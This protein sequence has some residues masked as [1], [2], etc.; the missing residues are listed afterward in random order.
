MEESA[1]IQSRKR[2]RS[3]V[4]LSSSSNPLIGILTRRKSRIYLHH[5]RSGI[6]RPDPDSRKPISFPPD[7]GSVQAFWG[8]NCNKASRVSS[9]K[10]LRSRRVFTPEVSSLLK[11][12]EEDLKD[13]ST[14]LKGSDR[15][16]AP[17]LI[18][19]SNVGGAEVDEREKN[20]I[21]KAKAVDEG[22]D[23]ENSLNSKDQSISGDG[24]I[25]VAKLALNRCGRKKVFRTPSSFSY[26]R[27]LPYLMDIVNDDSSV[28]KIEIV[29][30][31]TPCKL[32]KLDGA[33]SEV[34]S[35]AENSYTAKLEV[36]VPHVD[37]IKPS[38]NGDVKK[39]HIELP[40]NQQDLSGAEHGLSR[41]TEMT[42]PIEV[43]PKVHESGANRIDTSVGEECG[44]TTPP[45]RDVF[46]NTEIGPGGESMKANSVL[47]ENQIVKGLSVNGENG[48]IDVLR[49]S[50]NSK[51]GTE[52]INRLVPNPCSRLRL[53]KNPRSLS[54][55]RL[56]PF[57]MDMSKNNSCNSRITE[58]STAQAYLK[59][60]LHPLSTATT[61]KDYVNKTIVE[62]SSGVQHTQVQMQNLFSS[63]VPLPPSDGSSPDTNNSPVSS[64]QQSSSSNYS[65]NAEPSVFS[66]ETC[67]DPMLINLQTGEPESKRKLKPGF[68]CKEDS[69]ASPPSSTVSNDIRMEQ[70]AAEGPGPVG[71]EKM[72]LDLR[73]KLDNNI[74]ESIEKVN[75]DQ[76]SCQMEVSGSLF[77]SNNGPYKGI[78]KRNRRGCRGLCNCLNCV[79]FRLHAD[80]AFEFSRNQM[81]DAED[82][83]LELMKELANLRLLLEKTISDDNDHAAIQ[84]N[85]VQVKQACNKALET[86]NLAKD[87]L[88]QL[89]YDLSVHCRIPALL[90]PKVTFANYIQERAFPVIDPSTSAQNKR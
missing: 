51:G 52:Q 14:L 19:D 48:N 80:R 58:H 45:D 66:S 49:L 5:N 87:R 24:S 74:G 11:V 67:T 59:E 6:T 82:V 53:F 10:D 16:S 7:I 21:M 62:N 50:P 71:K 44:Q 61:E 65:S 90:Q 64:M 85:P 4:P 43:R 46:T 39:F 2:R 15:R 23:M 12:E 20:E 78:L 29:D 55:R 17:G 69:S 73:L 30:A 26:R 9:I 54:Y 38:D 22:N 83:A 1:D 8:I 63:M 86:E 32:Q 25:S 28:S 88:N 18:L 89:N 84:L 37:D 27:L 79:S 77:A 75:L 42:K 31:G 57:L 76:S 40:F 33:N 68:D 41:T 56:L 60:D 13:G 47:T 35:I 72:C 81:Q 3:R 70:S 36:V 34:W